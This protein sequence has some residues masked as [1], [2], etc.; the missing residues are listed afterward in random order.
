MEVLSILGQLADAMQ[1]HVMLCK[2]FLESL[3][4]APN[5][6]SYDQWLDIQR[7]Q[8]ELNTTTLLI[9]RLVALHQPSKTIDRMIDQLK[10]HGDSLLSEFADLSA[11]TY[12][13]VDIQHGVSETSRLERAYQ[14]CQSLLQ[15]EEQ[16][17]TQTYETLCIPVQTSFF[18]TKGSQDPSVRLQSFL[19]CLLKSVVRCVSTLQD[20]QKSME[21]CMKLHQIRRGVIAELGVVFELVDHEIQDVLEDSYEIWV[22]D[23]VHVNLPEEVPKDD[24]TSISS[25]LAR[26]LFWMDIEEQLRPYILQTCKTRQTLNLKRTKAFGGTHPMEIWIHEQLEEIKQNARKE[27]ATLEVEPEVDLPIVW[28][29]HQVT[30]I[31]VSSYGVLTSHSIRRIFVKR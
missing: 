8:S 27:E 1:S 12:Q 3:W 28:G 13:Y 21:E 10:E 9:S 24:L 16:V 19:Q 14:D 2:A 7:V 5:M 20:I 6:S 23:Q 31:R 4:K 11:D 17:L 15:L 25:R 22:E 26:C 18:I 29:L 30:P